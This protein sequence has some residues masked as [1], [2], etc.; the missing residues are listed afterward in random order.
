MCMAF[1]F[2]RCTVC[3][4][5]GRP[6]Q[7]IFVA[8]WNYW[9]WG[10][11][12]IIFF[13]NL[14]NT[15]FLECF[16][17]E[18][19]KIIIFSYPKNGNYVSL[20]LKLYLTTWSGWP[21]EINLQIVINIHSFNKI[22]VPLRKMGLCGWAALLIYGLQKGSVTLMILAFLGT[23]SRRNVR[24]WYVIMYLNHKGFGFV[25]MVNRRFVPNGDSRICPSCG[26]GFYKVFIIYS[27][28]N[29]DQLARLND[30]LKDKMWR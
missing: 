8:L 5:K 24:L 29:V 25:T 2:F 28:C 20:K 3:A 21:F 15:R 14:I 9:K 4:R 18:K 23:L 11:F 19:T 22:W 26:C 13:E 7:W 17:N 12:E 10:L 16:V 1:F 6:V 27:L 30:D